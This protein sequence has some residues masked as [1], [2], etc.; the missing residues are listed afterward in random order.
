MN[1]ILAQQQ[2]GGALKIR[3]EAKRKML[4]DK[5]IEM[6][7]KILDLTVREF[8]DRFLDI[9]ENVNKRRSKS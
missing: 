8:I 1:H 4:E 6:L 5:E 9:K 7:E 2:A 3:A